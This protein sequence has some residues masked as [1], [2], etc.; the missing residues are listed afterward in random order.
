LGRAIEG[1]DLKMMYEMDLRTLNQLNTGGN[2]KFDGFVK[3]L[4]RKSLFRFINC[5]GLRYYSAA[6]QRI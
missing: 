2:P 5:L 4:V 6:V 3:F 1:K